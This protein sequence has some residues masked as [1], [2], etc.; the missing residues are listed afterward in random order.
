MMGHLKC[1]LM[2]TTCLLLQV[3]QVTWILVNVVIEMLSGVY[4]FW[5]AVGYDVFS[6]PLEEK[7]IVCKDEP[8]PVTS[9]SDVAPTVLV[10][11][12]FG[13]GE[14]VCVPF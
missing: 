10:H 12:V 3:F 9:D 13:F 14:G 4:M 8:E 11:G 1:L 2:A 7:S 5:R 6:S